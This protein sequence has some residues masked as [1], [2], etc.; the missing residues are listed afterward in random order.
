MIYELIKNRRSL[1]SFAIISCSNKGN[2]TKK[3]KNSFIQRVF[4][5]QPFWKKKDNQIDESQLVIAAR[6]G[7]QDAFEALIDRYSPRLFAVAKRMVGSDRAEDI[8]QEA[9]WAAFKS[10]AKFRGDASFSSYLHTIVINRSKYILKKEKHN[11][12]IDENSFDYSSASE[13]DNLTNKLVLEQAL[14]KLP[15][16]FRECLVL[17]EL[18]GFSYKEIADILQINEGTVK[19][20]M[21]RA[22]AKLKNI[23]IEMGV[24]L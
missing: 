24:S 14:A 21:A 1:F 9:F 4:T 16:K 7:N 12:E 23:L 5:M 6:Y 18:S 2:R 11:L 13:V 10:L 3:L 8:V 17:R 22:R 20:R 19:S 15:S